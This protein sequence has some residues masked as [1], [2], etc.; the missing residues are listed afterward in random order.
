MTSSPAQKDIRLEV[1]RE[2]G[3]FF[4]APAMESS[5]IRKPQDHYA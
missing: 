5:A 3:I 2:L 1:N 4:N